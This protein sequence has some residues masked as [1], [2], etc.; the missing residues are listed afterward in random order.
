MCLTLT[1]LIKIKAHFWWFPSFR[2]ISYVAIAVVEILLKVAPYIIIASV[3]L[4]L[5]CW[6][7]ESR[8]SSPNKLPDPSLRTPS[9]SIHFFKTILAGFAG[10]ILAVASTF[11]KLSLP[12]SAI[13]LISLIVIYS[14][15]QLY[16]LINH[17]V[18]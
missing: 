12:F 11:I 7:F 8:F 9:E 15:Y 14:F 10:M 4:A 16:S 6:E 1:A 18:E 13:L 17:S 5:V 3:S 2:L